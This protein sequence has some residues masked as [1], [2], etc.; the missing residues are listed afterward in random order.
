MKVNLNKSTGHYKS[1]FSTDGRYGNITR[2][3]AGWLV[4]ISASADRSRNA[5]IMGWYNTLK[6]AKNEI[7]STLE[8]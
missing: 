8:K 4:W 2:C 3:S 1:D 7:I 6:E 5:F